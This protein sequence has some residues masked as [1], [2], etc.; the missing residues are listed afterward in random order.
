MVLSI[1][2]SAGEAQPADEFLGMSHLPAQWI[3]LNADVLLTGQLGD[4]VMGNWFDGTEQVSHR[5]TS[6]SIGA[7]PARRSAMER[8]QG[9][10]V[11]PILWGAFSSMLPGRRS[12]SP[13]DASAETSLT[14]PVA[15]RAREMQLDRFRRARWRGARPG[16]SHRLRGL[17][18][19]LE[20]RAL[21][22]PEALQ[23][24]ACSHPFSHR[25]LVEYMM[26]I[27]P[28]IVYDSR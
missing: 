15:S 12:V 10:P 9:R 17:V 7:A 28:E 24:R 2:P 26:T 25:P 22:C 14:A 23:R 11:Y 16:R 13:G 21:Q 20:N 1:R 4:L 18:E 6:G 19:T 27:P 3:T 8:G 5:L